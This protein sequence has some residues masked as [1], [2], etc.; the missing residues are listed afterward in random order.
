MLPNASS[1]IE[2]LEVAS[3]RHKSEQ[4]VISIVMVKKDEQSRLIVDNGEV[5]FV[6][7]IVIY[8]RS[9]KPLLKRKQKNSC[10]RE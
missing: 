1:D 9:N 4:D 10:S 3:W 2:L 6:Y 5:I 7:D 8:L